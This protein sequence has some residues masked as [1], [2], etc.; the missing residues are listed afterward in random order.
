LK[1]SK[2]FNKSKKSKRAQATAAST[3][4]ALIALFVILYLLLLPPAERQK[5]L[6]EDGDLTEDG[7]EVDHSFLLVNP[8]TLEKI[9]TKSVERQIP[10]VNIYAIEESKEIYGQASVF[11]KNSIFGE[12]LQTVNFKVKDLK[13]T[14]N[15][16][17]TFD[18]KK[19]KGYLMI[20]L[21][22]NEIYTAKLDK[23]VIDPIKLSK[24]LLNDGDNV[25]E[26]KVSKVGWMFLSVHNYELTN[27][28]VLADITDVSEQ[29][30]KNIFIVTSTEKNNIERA[31]LTFL[32]QCLL[33]DVGKL[34]IEINDHNIFS[35]IPNCG[36]FNI[37]E[38]L[39]D[40]L[41][42][43]ENT[44]VFKTEKG[45]YFVDVIKVSS[46]LKETSQPVY[47]F[48]ISSTK[49]N[50]IDAEQYPVYLNLE[51]ADA[52]EVKSGQIIINGYAK[53][54]NQKQR[55]YTAYINNYLVEGNNAIKIVPTNKLDIIKMG[56]YSAKES[57][58]SE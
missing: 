20:Y 54:I 7:V 50:E 48:E 24:D 29:K 15:V 17:L 19:A 30:S 13:N 32:P 9:G 39:P 46:K 11:V 2:K 8:G 57:T 42:S 3:L 55:K 47:Y 36:E 23:P 10:S 26:F 14:D 12:K 45:N 25:L 28:K 41:R 4:I 6:E 21:N 58:D 44:I 49:F 34:N 51:F 40:V 18:V 56:V 43:G 1:Y 35:A 52:V 31:K 33:D 37:I 16:I 38:F 22:G 27:I 5:I 53:G